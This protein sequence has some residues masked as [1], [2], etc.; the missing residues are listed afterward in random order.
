M[1]YKI[2]WRNI[3]RNKKRSLIII[4]A[5]TIG[6]STGI[7]LMAFYNG[8]VEQRVN[9]AIETEV[10][11]LQLHQPGFTSD[12]DIK[13][14]LQQGYTMLQKIQSYP[15]VKAAAGRFIIQGMIA[16]ASGNSG[17]MIN[18]VMPIEENKLTKLA[19]KIKQGNYFNTNKR[20]EV[21][22]GEKLRQKLKLKTGNKV[23]LTFQDADGNIASAAYRIAGIYQTVNTPYDE[24]NVFVRISDVDSVAGLKN[25]LNEIAVL[26]SSHQLLQ[27]TKAELQSLFP[28]AEIKDWMEISPEVGL[29]V[30]VSEQLVFILMI[31]ILMALAFGIVNT[32][33]MAVLE[34]TREIC[35]LLALGMNR[36]KVFGMILL[37][38]IFLVLA[39]CPG[40]LLI[41]LLA[42]S[43]THHTGIRFEK[44]AE[45]YSSFGYS[46]VL[47][48]KIT[49]QQ[50]MISM[51]LIIVTAIVSSLFPAWKAFRLKPI[52]SMRK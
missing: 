17:V 46:N 50:F 44:F 1:L 47:Y 43:I 25:R 12:Y 36:I 52:V 9:S 6:L 49:M 15:Q 24:T 13:L 3:W 2:A 32:M 10:S 18:G 8:L 11:H 38:T 41:S 29:T 37:E 33:M 27:H 35:M 22:V 26:L 48:P 34:R 7:F 19:G 23:V 28:A 30:S 40:G 51:L 21:L 45:V 20:N 31:I 4:I 42:I 39:G 5:V 14:Y 16:S